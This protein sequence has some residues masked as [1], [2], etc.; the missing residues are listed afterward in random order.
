[1]SVHL[2]G[3]PC[4]SMVQPWMSASILYCMQN[5]GLVDNYFLAHYFHGYNKHDFSPQELYECL[6]D[7]QELSNSKHMD[8]RPTRSLEGPYHIYTVPCIP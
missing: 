4:G 7:P 1:M 2:Q 6:P 8:M 5:E 3:F